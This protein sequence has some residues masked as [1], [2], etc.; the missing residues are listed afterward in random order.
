[1]GCVIEVSSNITGSQVAFTPD[2]T[3]RDL[4]GFKPKVLHQ[5]YNLS[6]YPV[7]ILSLDNFFIQ[8]KIAQGTNESGVIHNFTIDVDTGYK[9]LKQ[10]RGGVQWYM[11]ESKDF[12]SGVNF[13]LKNENNVLVSFNGPSITFR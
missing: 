10:F 8:T 1:M 5:E 11:L 13:K 6:D 3:I 7:D 12:I 9:F 2:D 4:L